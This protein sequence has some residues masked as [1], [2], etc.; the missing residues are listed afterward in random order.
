VSAVAAADTN[1]DGYSD[2]AVGASSRAVVLGFLGSATGL[3]TTPAYTLTVPAAAGFGASL[4]SVGD[5]NRDGASDLAA[6]GTGGAV[7]VFHGGATGAPAMART[8][9][10]GDAVRSLGGAWG[11]L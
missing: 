10:L 6:G 1:A 7:A 2:V 4:A 11:G 8:L 9:T 5:G 3:A